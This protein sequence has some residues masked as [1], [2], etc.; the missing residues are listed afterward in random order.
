P[1]SDKNDI[2]LTSST[3]TSSALAGD[4]EGIT[5]IL[6]FS[7][8]GTRASAL[9]YGV[10]EELRDTNVIIR[11]EST[12]LLDEVDFISSVSGGS[13]TAAYYGLFRDKIFYDFKDKLLTRD[14]KDQIVSRVL[15]PV[16]WFSSLGVT[17]HTARVYSEAGFGEYTFGDMLEK[18]PPYIAINATDLSQGARFSFLQDYFNL[19]CSDLSTFPVA[20]AVAASSAMPVLFDPVVLK[21]YDTCDVTDSINFLSR[22]VTTGRHSVRNTASA[23]ISYSNKEERPF[24][25]LVDGGVSDNLGLRIIT[26]P[27]ELA[28]GIVNYLKMIHG[29]D[30]YSTPQHFAIIAVNAS[31]KAN[32]SID[33][34]SVPPSMRQTLSAVTDAQLQLY[35][36]E[37]MDLLKVKLKHWVDESQT[38]EKPVEAHLITVELKSVSSNRLSSRLN[39]IPT[40]LGLPEE[41]VELLIGTGRKLLRENPQFQKLLKSISSHKAQ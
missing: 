16:R 18:G 34:S 25:H 40:T 30:N 29:G 23:A 24:I 20:R 39:L 10:L 8:G 19:I 37:T 9:S 1:T 41:E 7:G 33:K 32:S 11:G 2:N 21:N 3:L 28:G 31:V 4:P 5:L 17:D 26:D 13:I 6:A 15:N 22:K 27:V 36:N 12:R 14:L 38:L 35:N